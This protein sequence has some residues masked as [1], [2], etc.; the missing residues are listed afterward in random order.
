MRFCQFQCC[1][2]LDHFP[3]RE[4]HAKTW[5]RAQQRLWTEEVSSILLVA[6]RCEGY[7]YKNKWYPFENDIWWWF[8][9]CFIGEM[10]PIWLR[11]FN[12]IETTNE[13]FKN[14]LYFF[15]EDG[16][17]WMCQSRLSWC[18]KHHHNFTGLETG[19]LRQDLRGTTCKIIPEY[20]GPITRWS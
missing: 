7:V 18:Q 5:H 3:L 13:S 15:L 19:V 6:K 12:Q 16:T 2:T 20:V 10:I 14:L 9:T 17:I 1:P 8:E 11:C 4:T